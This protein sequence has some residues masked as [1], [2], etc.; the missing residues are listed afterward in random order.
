MTRG[1]RFSRALSIALV[2]SAVIPVPAA[3]LDPR[4][5]LTQY[6][7]NVWR[8]E[9]GLPHNT[10]R[11]IRQTRDG[12]LW[13]GTY[14]GLAR[15]DGVR[16][17]VYDRTN[18]VLTNNEVRC[19]HEDA[20][21]VLWVGT[22]AGGLYRLEKGELRKE[23]RPIESQTINAILSA[24]DGSLLV[25]TANGLYRLS[26][27]SG[28]ERFT[29]E[30][31]LWANTINALAQG[32]PG[33]VLIGTE[34]GVNILRGRAF[35]K[36][37]QPAHSDKAVK[38]LLMDRARNL[39]IG[40][41]TIERFAPSGERTLTIPSPD[42]GTH[43]LF[44]DPDGIVWVGTYGGGIGRLEKDVLNTYRQEQ[45]FLDRRAWTI[46]ADR[47]GGLWIGTRAGLVQFRDGTA[48]TYSRAEGFAGEIARAVF[49]DKDGA[50]YTGFDGG[51]SRF[52]EGAVHNITTRDGL[53]HPVVESVLRD[54]AGRLWI[55]TY[56][57][58]AEE[59]APG[60]FLVYSEKQ[61]LPR[62]AKW[63]YED[64]RGRLWVGGDTEI[65]F[66]EN[67]RAHTLD[68]KLALPAVTV[69]S[70]YED[71]DGW[72]WIG[73]LNHG[74]WRLK[75]DVLE[76]VP[77][78]GLTSI[79]VRTFL[80]DKD[81][82]LLVGTIGSGLFIRLSGGDFR[83]ITT[84]EGLGDDSVW[85][86]LD[87]GQGQVWM[88]SDRGVFRIPKRELL[89]YAAGKSNTVRINA[90]VGSGNGLKSRECNGG[91]NAP[92]LIA[93]DG[94]VVVP[95]GAGVAFIDPSRLVSSAPP[96]PARIEE[97]VADRVV[98]S[99][100]G[101]SVIPPGRRDTEIH[102]TGLSFLSPADLRF[103]YRLIGHDPDWIDAGTRRVA[104]YGGLPPGRY[105]FR[106][107]ASN[108][109]ATWSPAEDLRVIV[110]KPLWYQ[111]MAFRAGAV[112]VVLSLLAAAFAWRVRRLNVRARELA[113]LVAS[114]TAELA[115]R[116]RD[117]EVAN[118]TLGRLAITDDLTGI[119]NHRQLRE[120]LDR[121]WA[122]C[123]RN[124]EPISML[125]C[126]IDDFKAYNDTLGHQAG[127]VCLR[128]VARAINDTI[129]RAP[130]LAARYGGEEFAAVLPATDSDG[131]AAVADAI[132]EALHKLAMPHPQSRVGPT[133]T[134]SIGVATL[135]PTADSSV[136]RLIA[137]ADEA[138]YAAK[139][140]G[141]DRAVVAHP[142]DAADPRAISESR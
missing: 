70:F 78:L 61:G 59:V 124:R 122:R 94:R 92:G 98:V 37:P 106:V 73:T 87:D 138:L 42:L 24:P 64:R 48:V 28:V 69:Q 12:Y 62:G 105:E 46:T 130:D 14:G 67:G 83:Q 74:A 120:F 23:A 110:V 88:S 49:E 30:S 126:D 96:P 7:Q 1:L 50:I 52:F 27:S 140:A 43:A 118:A 121:E 85:S 60:E 65:G 113:A 116:T 29:N 108:D 25:G 39:Y 119:P 44:E 89:D 56:G 22:S 131:A 63:A 111:T 109:G 127:D 125:M 40:G 34:G 132:R 45:G 8:V 15:F 36:G 19:L 99:T 82:A 54:R 115:E 90:F 136:E 100:S 137:I 79:G 76:R 129:R 80:E 20:Q 133:V 81:G 104:Y 95:T 3:A 32:H 142:P 93:R 103:R 2:L 139:T 47:E 51:V 16:F 112:A 71:K 66:L 57:G 102:F 86:I 72:L 18:S 107:V 31:G 55:G 135:I 84:A 117:L 128:A 77:L 97:V 53:P 134:M 9:E 13:L 114:R 10:V 141:R 11:A 26:G 6:V 35:I 17:Q 5:A 68:A 21:G 41:R 75:D 4:K 33:E 101:E 123:A 58:L 38:T 91:G